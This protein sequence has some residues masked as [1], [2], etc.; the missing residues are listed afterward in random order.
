[1]K[2][3]LISVAIGVI[4]VLLALSVGVQSVRS[5]LFQPFGVRASS[6]TVVKQLKELSRLET[7]SFTIEKIIE[8]GKEEKNPFVDFLF[9][10]KLLLI[11]HGQVIAGFDLS[12]ISEK[13]VD[14]TG[15]TI[16]I[17]LPPPQILITSLDN[18]Q[19]K[20]YDKRQGLLSNRGKDLESD[21]RIAAEK[22]ITTS[23]C[24]DNI[25]SEAS[26]NAEK[27]LT[28]LFKTLGFTTVLVEI[29]NGTCQ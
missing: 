28:S 11:A 22:E 13:D 24:K 21:A 5:L 2:R 19:T 16:R 8:A 3:Y 18:T 6:Q 4:L 17:T 1:M 9:G 26:K 29:P 20:V 7:A 14:V 15:A 12:K 27:Q 23:A 10:D 25:L